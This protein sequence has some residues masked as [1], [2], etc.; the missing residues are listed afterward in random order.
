MKNFFGKIKNK[1]KVLHKS[2]LINPH[3]HWTTLVRLFLFLAFLLIIF[4]F[5]LLY[6]IKN[7][8]IFQ[9]APSTKESTPSLVN[10]KLFKKIKES[11]DGK[12]IRTKEIENGQ[13]LFSDPS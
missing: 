6:K 7:E 12:T 4:G 11:F 10:E 5:Y 8:Q 1:I 9:V 2:R 3:I 13:I